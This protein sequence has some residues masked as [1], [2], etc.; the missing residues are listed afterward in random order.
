M[1]LHGVELLHHVG[2]SNRIYSMHR[3]AAPTPHCRQFFRD[4]GGEFGNAHAFIK[5]RAKL[6]LKHDGFSFS[7]DQP[8]GTSNRY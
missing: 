4:I 2:Q 7:G 8:A 5:Q 3:R 1:P 6:R